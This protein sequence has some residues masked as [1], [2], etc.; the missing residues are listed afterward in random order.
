MIRVI[1]V[2]APFISTRNNEPMMSHSR[3][4]GFSRLDFS[5]FI[6]QPLSFIEHDLTETFEKGDSSAH[7][8]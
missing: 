7:L 4:L 6:F 3:V 2:I 5:I 8:Q 1:A